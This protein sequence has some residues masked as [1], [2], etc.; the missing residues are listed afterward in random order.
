MGMK[1]AHG[2]ENGRTSNGSLPLTA[3]I[4]VKIIS[5]TKPH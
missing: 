3:L 1:G 5:L 2:N 4:V